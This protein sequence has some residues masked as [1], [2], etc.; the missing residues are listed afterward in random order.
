MGQKQLLNPNVCF[1]E[2]LELEDHDEI[3]NWEKYQDVWLGGV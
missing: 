3:P 1:V 2:D